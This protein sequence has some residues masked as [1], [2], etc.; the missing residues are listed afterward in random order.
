MRTLT[1]AGAPLD[2]AHCL[3]RNL[4]TVWDAPL[5][6]WLQPVPLDECDWMPVAQCPISAEWTRW[7]AQQWQ[8]P[9]AFA[10]CYLIMLGVMRNLMR[11]RS[12]IYLRGA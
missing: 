9:L 7:T 2:S 10:F 4:T 5:W 11:G 6:E 3:Y 8:I 1:K 12:P